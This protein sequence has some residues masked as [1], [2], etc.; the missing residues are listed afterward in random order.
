MASV[1]SECTSAVDTNRPK[2][3]TRRVDGDS[4]I[5]TVAPTKDGGV[6]LD[7]YRS[8]NSSNT[9]I[10]LYPEAGQSEKELV[11]LAVAQVCADTKASKAA[12]AVQRRFNATRLHQIW[13]DGGDVA[14]LIEAV[15]LCPEHL[16][17]RLSLAKVR[18]EMQQY[19]ICISLCK[20][21]VTQARLP[22]ATIFEEANESI[23]VLVSNAYTLMADALLQSGT[24]KKDRA[25]NVYVLAIRE[26]PAND[27]ARSRL[28]AVRTP[29]PGSGSPAADPSKAPVPPKA[30]SVASTATD[31][32]DL[33]DHHELVTRSKN[34]KF[35]CTMCGECCRN[36]DNILLTPVDI[37]LMSRAPGMGNVHGVGTTMRLRSLFKSAFHWT[38]KDG[39]PVCYLRPLKAENNR[40]HFSYPLYRQGEKLL[41]YEELTKLGLTQEEEYTPVTADEYNITEDDLAMAAAATS[42]EEADTCGNDADHEGESSAEEIEDPAEPPRIAQKP[43]AVYNSY[44]RQ[45]LG[46]MFGMYNMPHMC[47]AYP[48]AK[49][50]SWADFW[51]ARGQCAEETTAGDDGEKIVIVRTDACEAFFPDDQVRTQPFKS[52]E[53]MHASSKDQTLGEFIAN[54]NLDE[55]WKHTDSFMSLIE[56]VTDTGI[57]DQLKDHAALRSKFQKRLAAIWYNPDNLADKDS[58]HLKGGWRTVERAVKQCTRVLI[59]DFK[60]KVELASEDV[61]R[62][63]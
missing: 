10:V 62:L 57:M 11:D 23:A 38:V 63:A 28:E 46:C 35:S 1:A 25:I 49:E 44:G 19:T 8:S 42:I 33:L 15:K 54:N 3:A 21:L 9:I 39:L 18:F 2:R 50:L 56:E 26:N 12:L 30:Q 24:G 37:W 36:A 51:H 52:A 47:T 31:I 13:S 4:F 6:S 48:I 59:A 20:R 5:V 55:R 61:Q 41:S 14:H 58:G 34:F 32:E 7:V 27:M 43:D 22:S 40:C 17:I 29:V 45:A 60:T 53:P 16:H